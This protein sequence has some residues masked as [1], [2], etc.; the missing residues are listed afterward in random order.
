MATSKASP[1]ETMTASEYQ[2]LVLTSISEKTFQARVIKVARLGGWRVSHTFN[3]RHSPEG[4][5][6]LGLCRPPRL[7]LIELKTE[8]GRLRP[9]QREWL[10]ALAQCPGIEVALWRPSD[11]PAIERV[12]LYGEVLTGASECVSWPILD[13]QGERANG[14]ETRENGVA[15]A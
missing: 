14:C 11:W 9:E 8:R 1:A 10:A 5:P 15:R 7:L 13:S 3:S 6:D 2:R 4:W 12:L